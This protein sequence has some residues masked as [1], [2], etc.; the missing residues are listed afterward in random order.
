M[1]EIVYGEIIIITTTANFVHVYN[2]PL[3]QKPLP[4]L[5]HRYVP[6]DKFNSYMLDT[7]LVTDDLRLMMSL[8]HGF[9]IFTKETIEYIKRN[10]VSGETY[11][12]VDQ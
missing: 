11:Y 10:A 5:K 7:Y 9:P 6:Y 12:A 3:E 8:R 4:Q 1:G 2:F